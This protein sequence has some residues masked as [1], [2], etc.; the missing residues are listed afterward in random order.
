MKKLLTTLL[1]LL[2]PAAP[3]L[4][5]QSVTLNEVMSSN[6]TAIF[7]EDGDSPDWIELFNPG[8]SPVNLAGFGI[9][10]DPAEPFKWVF[11]AITMEPQEYLLVFASG[12][13]QTGTGQQWETVINWGDTWKYL[14]PVSE[15][16]GNWRTL[17]F[18]DYSW[19]SGPSG[20]GYGDDDDST[21]FGATMSVFIRKVFTLENF[22]EVLEAVLH[23]DYDDGI[24]AYLNGMEV[25]RANL[26]TP[27]E[28]PAFDEPAI[29]VV[30]PLI[31]Q[32]GTPGAWPVDPDLIL[33]GQNILAIEVHNID[34]TSSDLTLIPFFSLLL[35]GPPP[36]PNG[37]PPLL[38][39]VSPGLHTN[40]KI[41]STGE[42]VVLTGPEGNAADSVHTGELPTD[43]SIGRQPDGSGSW[44]Y[45]PES[46]P[47][48]S[49]NTDSWPGVT[50]LVHFSQP[51]GFYDNAQSVVL[52]TN[53]PGDVIY[54][55]TD[56]SLPDD[57]SAAYAEPIPVFVTRVIRAVAVHEGYLPSKP[58]AATF[59]INTDHDLPVFSLSTNPE[60]LFDPNIG[61]YHENNIWQDWERPIHVEFFDSDD[62][63]GFTIDGGVKL[64][65]AWTRTLPQKSLA[66]FAR[67]DYGYDEVDYPLFPDLPLDEFE[68]FVLRNSGN[69]WSVTMFRDG[70]MTGLVKEDGVDIPAFRPSVVYINGDYWG[71]HNIRE[72]LDDRYLEAH[73]GIRHDSIDLL[74]LNAQPING[75]ATHYNS[76][77]NFIEDN[78]LSYP[79][80]YAYVKTQMDV[81]EFIDY[82]IA[83]IFVNNTDWPGNN[84]KFWRPDTLGGRWRW[85]L[86]DTDFGFGLVYDYTY[87]TLAFAT[88]E[89]GPDWPNPPWS[90]YLLRQLLTSSLFRISFINRYA[91]LLNSSFRTDTMLLQI[92]RKKNFITSEMPN[93]I[94]RWGSSMWDWL[95]NVQVLQTFATERRVHAQNHVV[96]FFGLTGVSELGLDVSP[97]GAG[98]IHVSTLE[99]EDFPWT[100]EYFNGIP[101]GVKAIARPGY[102]FTGWQ[103]S[104]T[105]ENDSITISMIGDMALTA[106]FEA[107]TP[108]SAVINEINYNSALDFNTEDWVEFYNPYD[109]PLNFAGWTF[110]DEEDIHGFEFQAATIIPPQGYLV[111]CADTAAFLSFFPEAENYAGNFDFGLSGGG[112]LLRLY[113]FSGL[114]IDTVHY[115]DVAPWP[116]DAD[117]LGPTL[118]LIDPALDNALP[119]SWAA[120]L[121]HGTP[122]RENGIYTSVEAGSDDPPAACK[123]IP[124]PAR[125]SF[126]FLLTSGT[127]R[128]ATIEIFNAF[129]QLVGY[130][131]GI[132]LPEGP[133]VI[134]WD[135]RNLAAGVYYCRISRASGNVTLKLIRT[136]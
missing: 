81:P 88:E 37:T 135:G 47:G 126:S 70:F 39:L 11:P 110:K 133:R 69:D 99:L 67:E 10:D 20:F 43:V 42:T 131:T 1:L 73:H 15:P 100:G 54:Y 24:V 80:N 115:D 40:F 36:D 118:E 28:L 98:G 124:N 127:D 129:G 117:G 136:E 95:A 106:V 101:F 78:P 82:E 14:V 132:R 8:A 105:S 6:R 71:I 59:F 121:Q 102:L 77:M 55:T 30:E 87:N 60:N 21:T 25:A 123:I 49:N 107:Y 63:S 12:K 89:N 113:D 134:P 84:I 22:P 52:S 50:G 3:G 92:D 114:L 4:L 120:Y 19:P 66:I 93:H 33:P 97:P 17:E 83:Q 104:I 31:Y 29:E 45:F 26:G 48:T 111:L 53:T 79:P 61:I 122:G 130:R 109:Q 58:T 90:T 76:L 16:A 18:P 72:K 57:G 75:D 64:Y 85:I 103:G 112:E 74:E 44:V 38:H 34:L 13:N 7:D 86:Y 125:G 46:T 27:G 128:E 65:G 119:E 68:S 2:L 116:P 62:S 96:Q 108:D 32:G 91:D 5:A 9:S 56:G 23:V 35:S 41:N 94:A 51:A